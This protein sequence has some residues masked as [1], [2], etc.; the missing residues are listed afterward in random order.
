MAVPQTHRGRKH[1]KNTVTWPYPN[2]LNQSLQALIPAVSLMKGNFKKDHLSLCSETN[3]W[4]LISIKATGQWN[5]PC[6]IA[7]FITRLFLMLTFNKGWGHQATPQ[8]VKELS[9]LEAA[10]CS[11]PMTRHRDYRKGKGG[12]HILWASPPR[13]VVRGKWV[14]PC[15][16]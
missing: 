14:Q 12:R 15:T 8:P 1:F 2:L 9:P 16:Q 3:S 10:L 11:S 7:M 6:S 4:H 13:L 5:A